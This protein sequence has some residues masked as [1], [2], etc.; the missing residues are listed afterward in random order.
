MSFP[1][2][3][4]KSS[5]PLSRA[6]FLSLCSSHLI[7]PLLPP[8]LLLFR[9]LPRAVL[10]THIS[11]ISASFYSPC[12]LTLPSLQNLHCYSTVPPI[13]CND[14]TFHGLSIELCTSLLYIFALLFPSWEHHRPLPSY[15]LLMPQSVSPFRCSLSHIKWWMNSLFSWSLYRKLDAFIYDAAVLNYMARKDE[16]CKVSLTLFRSH[17][18]Q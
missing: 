1:P 11:L 12:F 18:F 3:V 10:L 2:E 4:C 15:L 7:N 9:L 8:P 17:S 13:A 5:P 14:L 16:G 6:R